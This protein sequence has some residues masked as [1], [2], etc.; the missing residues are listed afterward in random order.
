MGVTVEPSSTP[1]AYVEVDKEVNF[2]VTAT[3]RAACPPATCASPPSVSVTRLWRSEGRSR[4]RPT[5]AWTACPRST[6]RPAGGIWTSSAPRLPVKAAD[7]APPLLLCCAEQMCNYI[8]DDYDISIILTP[9]YNGTLTRGNAPHSEDNAIYSKNHHDD[10][11]LWFKAA[12]IAVPIAGGFILVLLVL[13]AVRMLRTDSRHHRRLLQVRRER[14]LTKAHMC[15]TE[16]FVGKNSKQQCSLFSEKQPGKACPQ[17]YSDLPG[18][19]SESGSAAVVYG[20]LGEVPNKHFS[21]VLYGGDAALELPV[22]FPSSA[23]GNGHHHHHHASNGV[24]SHYHHSNSSLPCSSAACHH[25][26]ASGC[27]RTAA[28]G[29]VDAF[30]RLH[31]GAPS[32]TNA[33]TKPR[34]FYAALDPRSATKASC[35]GRD[36]AVKMDR[37][38]HVHPTVMGSSAGQCLQGHPYTVLATWDKTYTKGAAPADV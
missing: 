29:G 18:P 22:N 32:N 1:V 2:D 9:K 27:S 33:V 24:S 6:T 19:V 13:L 38:G 28:G 8:R 10:R 7:L 31:P 14:S 23:R 26:D 11:D 3:N 12:V 20:Q 30:A 25:G 4:I 35:P 21:H 17:L 5:A 16:Y 36:V 37:S 34:S 15:I